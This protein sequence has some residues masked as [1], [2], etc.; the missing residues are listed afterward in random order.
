MYLVDGWII[1]NLPISI[2]SKEYP[3][4]AVSVQLQMKKYTWK[5]NHFSFLMEQSY[6]THII[7]YEKQYKLWCSRMSSNLYNHEIMLL[8]YD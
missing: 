8:L 1:E 6:Q 2:L 4:I 3:I 7:F 5:K